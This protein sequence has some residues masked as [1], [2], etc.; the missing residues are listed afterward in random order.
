M[1]PLHAHMTFAE[2]V[3]TFLQDAYTCRMNS[4]NCN[5]C[6][7]RHWYFS[8]RPVCVTWH[9]GAAIYFTCVVCNVYCYAGLSHIRTVHCLHYYS[10]MSWNVITKSKSFCVNTNKTRHRES[11]S[12]RWHFVLSLCC[13]SNETRAPI[14]N[15]PY[16]AQLE[17]TL[18]YF[19][20]LH[21]GP[22]SNVGMQQGTDRRTAQTDCRDQYT[23]ISPRCTSRKM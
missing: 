19:R 18:Y 17:G 13:Y 8:C 4:I 21:P 7:K 10:L 3:F 23:Y 6:V 14:A 15:P 11:T 5:L 9:V 20:K 2:V 1:L 12:T 16:S 22:C